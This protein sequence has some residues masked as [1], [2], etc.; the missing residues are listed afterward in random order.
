MVFVYVFVIVLTWNIVVLVT[1][2]CEF[3]LFQ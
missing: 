1:S 3:V 2:L